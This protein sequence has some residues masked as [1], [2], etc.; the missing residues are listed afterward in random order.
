MPSRLIPDPVDEEL[1]VGQFPRID[2]LGARLRLA[3]IKA[4]QRGDRSNHVRHGEAL[5]V[6][7]AGHDVRAVELDGGKGHAAFWLADA[8][9][10]EGLDQGE[11]VS[12]CRTPGGG[13]EG[14]EGGSSGG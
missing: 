10:D 7:R 6:R 4:Q 1:P 13:P 11:D 12:A 9:L 5:R 8:R 3:R 14:E 2:D